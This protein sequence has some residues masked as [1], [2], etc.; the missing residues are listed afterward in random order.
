MVSPKSESAEQVVPLDRGL[1]GESRVD[2]LESRSA[3]PD[4]IGIAAKDETAFFTSVTADNVDR[5]YKLYAWNDTKT[6]C[7]IT[8]NSLLFTA[9]SFLYRECLRETLA[10][11]FLGAAA[12]CFGISLTFC[13]LQVFPRL[14]SRQTGS[15]PNVRSLRGINLFGSWTAY[16]DAVK[17]LKEEDFLKDTARQAYGMAM[18]NLRSIAIIKRGVIFTVL[19]LVLMLLAAGF[20]AGAARGYQV[21]GP[22]A[23]PQE[24]TVKPTSDSNV[25]TAKSVSHPAR[26]AHNPHRHKIR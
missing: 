12:L 1:G 9:V 21:L 15:E 26:R 11:L 13:L 7:L 25:G 19:G 3:A 14:T 6:I 8:A 18:N 17:K 10:L 4:P 22:W 5:Q 2:R 24:T 20:S 16:L 23:K